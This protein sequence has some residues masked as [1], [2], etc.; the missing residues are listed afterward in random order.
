MIDRREEIDDL[1]NYIVKSLEKGNHKM[2]YSISS[3]K[4]LDEILDNEVSKGKPINPKSTFGELYNY[5][6]VAMTAYLVKVI[7]KNTQD[8]EL[9]F[10]SA[11]E[12]WYIDFTI[13][14]KNGWQAQPG[15]RIIKRIMNGREDELYSY[16][17]SLCKY[18]NDPPSTN[19]E[20][21]YTL[22]INMNEGVS[23]KPWW[24][25]W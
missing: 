24:K 15:Q 14:A 3:V 7:E 16:V 6:L 25:I 20:S 9:D 11:R 17:K 1:S 10:S 21:S 18:F 13:K 4:V 2:D 19:E 22:E 12:D 8:T 5:I 23:R